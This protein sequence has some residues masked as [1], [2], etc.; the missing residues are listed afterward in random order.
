MRYYEFEG[1]TPEEAIRIALADTQF[2]KEEIKIEILREGDEKRPAKIRIYVDY[3]EFE[4]IENFIL[5]IIERMGDKGEC[6]FSYRPPKIHI[7][8][9]TKK[10]DNILIGKKGHVLDALE[11]LLYQA[12]KK[13]FPDY[14]V[15]LDINN[16]RKK[17]IEFLINKAKAICNVV[18]KT[19]K[20]M[21]FDPV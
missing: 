13:K 21:S 16:Y 1:R 3:P 4:F 12:F 10:S 8:L 15:Y 5:G 14:K 9:K 6:Y 18:R 2:K 17:R 20:E 11:F 7:N 19:K